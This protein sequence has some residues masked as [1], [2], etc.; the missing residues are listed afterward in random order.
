MTREDTDRLFELIAVFRPADPK[1]KNRTLRAAWALVL[2]PYEVN[3]VRAAVADYFRTN[4]YFPD[5]TD[6]SSRCRQPE[7]P[8]RTW[9]PGGKERKDMDKTFAW[10]EEWHREL[11]RKGL[12]TLRDAIAQGKTPGEWALELERAGVWE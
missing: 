10:A 4:K 7:K 8:V 12:P 2:E 1:L 3:D 5:V 6:I 9:T 11:K